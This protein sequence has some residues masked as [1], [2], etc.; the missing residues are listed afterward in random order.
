M[1]VSAMREVPRY[2]DR[3][4]ATRAGR[5]VGGGLASVDPDERPRPKGRRLGLPLS[6]RRRDKAPTRWPALG[7]KNSTDCRRRYSPS[8]SDA[9]GNL[10]GQLRFRTS[11]GSKSV[12]VHLT[13]GIV[14][15]VRA[16]AGVKPSQIARRFGLSQSDVRKALAID[17]S[18]RT[19][20][21]DFRPRGS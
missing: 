8:R 15:A 5:A 6:G 21:R 2:G 12:A 14:N 3:Q 16:A 1:P 18:R 7:V 20:D 17:A 19:P 10:A 11:R 4:T 9:V 13:P